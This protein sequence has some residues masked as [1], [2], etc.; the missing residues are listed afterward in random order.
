MVATDVLTK[1]ISERRDEG[2]VFL[3]KRCILSCRSKVYIKFTCKKGILF[4]HKCDKF[5]C[6]FSVLVCKE[7]PL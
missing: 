2:K 5:K 7:F 4:L 1:W 3:D 6:V